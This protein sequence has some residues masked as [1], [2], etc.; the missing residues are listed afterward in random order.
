MSKGAPKGDLTVQWVRQVW[1]DLIEF[2][3]GNGLAKNF[4]GYQWKAM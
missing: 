4:I 2:K 3:K 1:E